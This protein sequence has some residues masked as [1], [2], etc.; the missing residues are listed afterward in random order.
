MGPGALFGSHSE[1]YESWKGGLTTRVG[2]GGTVSVEGLGPEGS[3][4][5]REVISCSD[6]P[7]VG[8]PSRAA[9]T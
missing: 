8:P 1:W 7:V 9:G 2:E 5:L 4:I 6:R 3:F